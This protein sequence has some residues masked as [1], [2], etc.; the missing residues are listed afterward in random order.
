MQKLIYLADTNFLV[1]KKIYESLPS[2]GIKANKFL[3]L[4]ANNAFNEAIGILHTLLCSTKKEELLI[5][6]LL[7]KI[8]EKE[9]SDSIF[10]NDEKISQFFQKISDDYPYPD[11]SS[12]TFLSIADG[13]LIGDILADIRKKKRQ[14]GLTNLDEIKTEFEKENFYKIRHQS[15]AHKNKQLNDPAGATDLYLKDDYIEKL[16]VIVKKLRLCSYFWFDYELRNPNDKIICDLE[17]LVNSLK[18]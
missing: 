14:S 5:K 8:I 3:L 17:I 18:N 1:C 16:G 15:V 9:K 6:S 10:I 11:Y 4:S 7:E 12:Y 2:D 13:R